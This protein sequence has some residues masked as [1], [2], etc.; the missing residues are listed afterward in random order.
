MK[1]LENSE[2]MSEKMQMLME[3]GLS[4][5]P[6]EGFEEDCYCLGFVIL[7]VLTGIHPKTLPKEYQHKSQTVKAILHERRPALSSEMIEVVLQLVERE[8]L[9]RM[10]NYQLRRLLKDKEAEIIRNEEFDY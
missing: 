3:K 9:R 6:T 10:D 7:F 8:N 5:S 2:L 1:K 4:A